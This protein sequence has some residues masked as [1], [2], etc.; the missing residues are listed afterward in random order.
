VAKHVEDI[1]KKG[2]D[3]FETQ[4]RTKD[5]EIRDILVSSRALSIRGR[6]FVQSIWT[7]ITERKR[8][9]EELLE[10]E[11][12]LRQFFENEPEYCYMIS[13]DGMILDLNRSAL[14]MLGYRKEEILGKPVKTIY[15]PE[16]LPKMKKLFAKWRKTGHFADE[17]MTIIT[18]NGDRRVVLLS[19]GAVRD[20]GGKA[21]H[22]VSVQRD[23]TERKRAEKAL[24]IKDTAIASSINAIALADPEGRLTYVNSS[25]LQLWG[26]EDESEV[27]GKQATE[28]WKIEDKAREVMDM[29]WSKGAWV[30][31]LVA[32]R[33]GGTLFDVHLAASSVTDE[34]GKPIAMMSSFVDITE[35][36]RVEEE[37]RSS[38]ERFRALAESTSDWIWEIDSNAVFTYT[39][40]K[41]RDSLGY[42]PEQIL[43]KRIFDLTSEDEVHRTKRFFN[44][45]AEKQEPFDVFEVT[46]LHKDGHRV[47][48]Q[49][50]GVP[51]FDQKGM[52]SGYRGINRDITERLALEAQL[53]QS[54]K[55][56][57]IGTLAG[58]VAHEIN[59]PI[60]GIMNYAQLI[61]DELGPDSPVAD[62]AAEIG[63]ETRRVATIVRN[64]L[65]F[66]RPTK[67]QRSPA[68]M[69]DIVEG[70]LSL[71]RSVLQRDQ[72]TLQVDV[73]ED[74]PKVN[75]RSQQ[76]HQVIMNLLTNARDALNEKYPE[77]NE[78]KKIFISAHLR[79][80]RK[81][82]KETPAE[83]PTP[84]RWLRLTVEDHGP[85]IR[86]KMR[87][88]LFDP[89]YTSK[90]PDRGTG[91]G[92]SI[93]YTIV[94][95]HG[96]QLSVA[97][98]VGKWTRFHVD[99]PIAPRLR[100]G[101]AE[102]MNQSPSTFADR[103]TV[104][105]SN[106]KHQGRRHGAR[107]AAQ[108]RR[109]SEE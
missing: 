67:E 23:I 4:H 91:L 48:F 109:R 3:T 43:G 40:P 53:R 62:F 84:D 75:C 55:L 27:I 61:L 1:V 97:S 28:F 64:L 106:T 57:S 58:G 86:K 104:D 76:I 54:Q 18:K 42:D 88:H 96:G 92:L 5:G 37:L 11:E 71:I 74:L 99:L 41:V 82:G 69:C 32:K 98:K 2:S 56:E 100:L 44:E 50:S 15:A 17:E 59:N 94:T 85:G 51:V 19:A 78:D 30:G 31:E 101:Q 45:T 8:V 81:K 102:P 46:H 72:I 90:R 16:S 107:Q 24:R 35:R 60:N 20:K 63:K 10:S 36:K 47:V 33:K 105:K 14:D 66:S 13:P 95:E 7:D 65:D 21:L 83:I 73:P 70:T 39:N 79:N 80:V 9:E 26:F 87:Q 89:F 77:H 38:R 49:I 108:G 25:F 22:S 29:L 34:T 52:L 12:R 93:S 6:N 68:R 103:A